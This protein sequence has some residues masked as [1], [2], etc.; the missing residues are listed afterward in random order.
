MDFVEEKV[1]DPSSIPEEDYD[2]FIKPFLGKQYLL[3]IREGLD[4]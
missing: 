2:S 3:E 4:T 1:K